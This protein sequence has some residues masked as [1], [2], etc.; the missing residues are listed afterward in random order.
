MLGIMCTVR[1]GSSGSVGGVVVSA[2]EDEDGSGASSEAGAGDASMG[3][4][5]G[6]PRAN[7]VTNC[8]RSEQC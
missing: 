1:V 8:T 4:G 5:L 7:K 2:V 3:V 6:G